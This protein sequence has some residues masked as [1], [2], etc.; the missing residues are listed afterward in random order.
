MD[1]PNTDMHLPSLSEP[2]TAEAEAFLAEMLLIYP[3]LGVHAFERVDQESSDT[4]RLEGVDTKAEGAATAD[5]FVVFANSFGRS[6]AVP[7]MPETGRRVRAALIAKGILVKEDER[8]RLTQDHQFSS[9]STASS[10]ML[11]RSSNGLTDW[12]TSDGR[13]LK[14]VQTA[15]TD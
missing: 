13:T 9:P 1:N 5:G 14:D 12:K 6:K 3:V 4:L 2:E 10:V 7:S 15:V 11:G 8:L